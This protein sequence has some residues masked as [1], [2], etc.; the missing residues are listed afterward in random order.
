MEASIRQL[1]IDG[2]SKTALDT[3]KE[4]HKRQGNAASEELLVEAYL[5]RI[6]ALSDQN[7]AVEAASLI[8]LVRE[9]F[10]SARE[11]IDALSAT[12]SARGGN[13]DELLGPLRDPGLSPDR[14]ASIEQV[15]Q[16]QVTDLAALAGCASLPPEH[17][18][19]QAAAAIDK[20]FSAVTSGPVTDEQIALA[21]VSRR[22]PL[23]P[24]KLLIHAIACFYRND[25]K[26]CE[27]CLEAIG[28]ESAPGRIVHAMRAMLDATPAANLKPAEAALLSRSRVELADLRAAL[29]KLESVFVHGKEPGQVFKAVRDAVRECRLGA[30]D[31]LARLQQLVCMRTEIAGLD[32]ERMIVAL[33]GAPRRD[34]SFFRDLAQALESTG[35]SED[36]IR[37]CQ[38]W[39]DFRQAAVREGWFAE[40]GIEVA[41]LYL[42]MAGILGRMPPG[43]LRELQRPA[44]KAVSS[45]SSYFQYPE[46]LYERA[47]LIDPHPAAFSQWLRWARVN[48]IGQAENVARVWNKV[49]PTALDPLLF[50][51]EQAEQRN[52]FPTA[53]SWLDK[54]EKIDAV[55]SAVRSAR[56]RLLATA[57]LGQLQKKKPHLASQRLAEI[58]AL[59]QSQQGDRPAFLATLRLLIAAVS[60]DK[61]GT[62]A[63][64][65]EVDRALGD[66]LAAMI[67]ILGCAAIAKRQDLVRL[68][69]PE[70]LTAEER[71]RIPACLARVV[72]L[73]KD[74]GIGGKFRLPVE[75]VDE[76]EAQLPRVAAFLAVDRLRSLGELG[77]ASDRRKLAWAASVA[78]LERGGT[79]E[80]Y[81]LLLRARAMPEDLSVRHQVLTGAAAELGRFHRDMDVVDR[82]VEAGRNRYDD[83]PLPLTADQVREVLRKEM[84]SPAFPSR[85]APG[86]D[87]SELFPDPFSGDLCMCPSCRRERGA[88]PDLDIDSGSDEKEMERLFYDNAPADIPR[89]I[90]PLLFEAAK[91][92]FLKGGSTEEIVSRILG[93]KGGGRKKGRRR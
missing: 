13:L 62:D 27:E 8:A 51:M 68:P 61:P 3:A 15:I 42:H 36:L 86:P 32:F 12:A 30:P 47:C 63:A 17:G 10:P 74:I 78:G 26:S 46:Q 25:D 88:F 82:A 6:Q 80:A 43:L 87:Y 84:A 55:S 69:L 23:A 21:E 89:D 85:Y 65:L 1:I 93:G 64:R 29:V 81:F 5:A 56:L 24:W 20:A 9:R 52:A 90:L 39:D 91:E 83:D 67:L 28:P 41:A 34:A 45:E 2:K 35:D 66:R 92:A 54:A 31:L 77:I 19:R 38:W 76:A 37:A 4:F 57:A 79:T 49:I 14:R 60:G 53:I 7:L 70:R 71:S 75:Y 48:S 72:A 16:N 22:S 33:G 18:L 73:A 59:S 40:R 44:G 11:R 50:L 58:A